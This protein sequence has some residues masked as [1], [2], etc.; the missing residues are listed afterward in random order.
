LEFYYGYSYFYPYLNR[1]GYLGQSS[2]FWDYAY[3]D[4]IRYFT[5]CTQYSDQKFKKKISNL[6]NSLSKVLLLRGV[7][8]NL[9]LDSSDL[10]VSEEEKARKHMGLIAQELMTVFP[11][12]VYEDSLGYSV[13]YI[14]LIPVLI[15]A[16][17]EQ[18]KKIKKLEDKIKDNGAG[19]KGAEEVTVS[20]PEAP[21]LMQN[22]PNPFRE[23]TTICFFLP[24][25]IK[26]ADLYI[27]DMQGKQVKSYS[28]NQRD[29]GQ[30]TI[31]GGE[32]KAG[33]Y[34]YSLV[35]DGEVIGTKNMILT[36]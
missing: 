25:G 16:I 4:D 1:T 19:V 31:Q 13:D 24:S 17:K 26:K 7:Q 21:L 33:M 8:Y 20:D 14:C 6:E 34:Y 36:D 5:S 29:Y 18:D 12:L 22:V 28:T 35:A 32:L 3:V 2:K 15:E 27:Y 30:I 11:D 23:N 9:A 10:A